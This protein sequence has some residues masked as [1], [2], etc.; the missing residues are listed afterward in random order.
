MN[1]IH[2]FTKDTNLGSGCK[3]PVDCLRLVYDADKV[4]VS[5]YPNYSRSMQ[6]WRVYKP[7]Q[8]LSLLYPTS[9]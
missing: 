2:R 3:S 1:C 9:Q 8:I 5:K 7:S 4:E 6:R